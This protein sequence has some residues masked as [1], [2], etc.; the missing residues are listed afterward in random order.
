MSIFPILLSGCL[1]NFGAGGASIEGTG[2]GKPPA[3]G[4]GN[5]G[6]GIDHSNYILYL[7]GA[8]KD[9][10]SH[11]MRE[12]KFRDLYTGK[13]LYSGARYQLSLAKNE[14]LMIEV[15]SYFINDSE[16]TMVLEYPDCDVPLEF[17]SLEQEKIFP[18]QVCHSIQREELKPKA[19]RIFKL[20]YSLSDPVEG[21]W[22]LSSKLKLS[23]IHHEDENCSHL[24]IPIFLKQKSML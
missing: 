16:Y 6:D 2:N 10:C 21:I 14:A 8:A 19:H 12:L 23:Q 3:P 7:G 5:A 9:H 20:S 24:E 4:L 1:D 15:E 18:S 22:K 17:I 11:L 13:D